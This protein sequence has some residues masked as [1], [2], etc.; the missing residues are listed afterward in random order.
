MRIG[1]AVD[2]A[3]LG[4]GRQLLRQERIAPDVDPVAGAEHQVV[5][6][7]GGAVGQRQRET[8]TAGLGAPHL[9]RELSA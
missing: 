8:V 7:P 4:G 1:L 5:D 3:Q 9:G 2:D 6:P